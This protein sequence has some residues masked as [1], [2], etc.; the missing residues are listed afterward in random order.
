MESK[1]GS[2]QDPGTWFLS[3]RLEAQHQALVTLWHQLHVDMKSL[4]AWQSLSRDIQLIRSWSL[5]TVGLHAG[6]GNWEGWEMVSRRH[7]LAWHHP[8]TMCATSSSAH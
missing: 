1:E 7:R 3:S 2:R 5:V 4:L 6:H 8:Q